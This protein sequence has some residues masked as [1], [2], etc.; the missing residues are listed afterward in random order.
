MLYIYSDYG[1]Y[2]DSTP[3]FDYVA[4]SSYDL[5]IDCTDGS[6]TVSG[7]F[8]VSLIKNTA[9]TFLNLQSKTNYVNSSNY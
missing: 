5:T 6:N 4:Q 2:S 8:E 1:I 3:G 7:T 9:P